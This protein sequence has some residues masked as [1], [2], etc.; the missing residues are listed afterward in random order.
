MLEF[1][2]LSLSSTLSLKLLYPNSSLLQEEMVLY[3][4]CTFSSLNEKSG[5]KYTFPTMLQKETLVKAR[6]TQWLLSSAFHSP[7]LC[8]SVSSSFMTQVLS[9]L[10]SPP[11]HHLQTNTA[12]STRI[13]FTTQHAQDHAAPS[14]LLWISG[15]EQQDTAWHCFTHFLAASE[16]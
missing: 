3:F 6:H 7:S 15:L 16:V 11:A 4:Q 10:F 9:L 12:H 1:F 14:T 2:F 8:H 5:E 13:L